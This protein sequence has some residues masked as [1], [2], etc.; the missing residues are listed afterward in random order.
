MKKIVSV[1]LCVLFTISLTAC[2]NKAEYLSVLDNSGIFSNRSGEELPQTI[3]H[4][5]VMNHFGDSSQ[6]AGKKKMA[7]II[8]VDGTRADG[9]TI[10]P[11]DSGIR[12]VA[13]E[14]GLYLSFAGGDEDY[15]QPTATAPGWTSILTGVWA[16]K[17]GVTRNYTEKNDEYPTFVTELAKKY[18]TSGMLAFGWDGHV[19]ENCRSTYL[20]EWKAV[21]ASGLDVVYHNFDSDEQ[22]FKSMMDMAENAQNST[23]FFCVFDDVDENGEKS[24]FSVKKEKYAAEIEDCNNKVEKIYNAIKSRPTF[25]EEDWLVIVTTDHGGSGHKHGTH[26]IGCTETWIACNKSIDPHALKEQ[27]P[28]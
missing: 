23:A 28:A 19:G 7:C 4:D 12:R 16:D 17:H 22:I 26:N 9:M 3:V 1:F 13:A 20:P 24:G 25:S 2:E 6:N 5:V 18:G 8:G 21:Q 27:K 11:E 14:G 10:L 15:K